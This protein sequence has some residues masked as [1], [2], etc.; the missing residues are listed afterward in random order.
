LLFG[1]VEQLERAAKKV[2]SGR[3]ARSAALRLLCCAPRV[4]WEG[5]RN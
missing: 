4:A 3:V 5:M 1:T 2:Q